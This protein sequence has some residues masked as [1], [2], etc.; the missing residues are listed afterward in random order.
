MK[1]TMKMMMLA[2][3]AIL[4]MGFMASCGDSSEAKKVAEKITSGETLSQADYTVAIDYL[5]KFA[6]KAQPI[7]DEI[8]NLSATDPKAGELQ[9]QLD[10]LRGKFPL[11]ATF[12]GALSKASQSEVGAD[13][14]ALVDKYAGYEWFT[15][16]DWATI[17]TDPEAAGI[18]LQSPADD[19]T[20]VVAGAVD[21]LKVKSGL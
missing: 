8:N 7:Q 10:A 9:N 19:S 17:E 5:G 14:V 2:I 13:N 1:K 11:L 4:G 21:E 12:N 16:P 20:G 6:E 3:V 15:A 18:E